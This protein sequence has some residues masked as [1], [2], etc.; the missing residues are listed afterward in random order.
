[1]RLEGLCV[2]IHLLSAVKHAGTHDML[3]FGTRSPN[4]SPPD[5]NIHLVV[6]TA[7]RVESKIPTSFS[8]VPK[9]SRTAESCPAPMFSNRF[10]TEQTE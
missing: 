9:P 7:M 4:S 3:N 1:M 2:D 6:R 5:L 10:A 8:K